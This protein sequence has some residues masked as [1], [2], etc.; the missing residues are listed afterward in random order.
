MGA[1]IGCIS[2]IIPSTLS[3]LMDGKLKRLPT[4]ISAITI[5]LYVGRADAVRC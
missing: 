5:A 3:K 2:P 1:R 4:A